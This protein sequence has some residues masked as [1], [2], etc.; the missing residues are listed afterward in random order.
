MLKENT[1]KS[2]VNHWYHMYK[3][4]YNLSYG[5]NVLLD[6]FYT[7]IM[8]DLIELEEKNERR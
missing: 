7:H 2:I 3:K 5:E 8:E 6:D 1:P 4:T